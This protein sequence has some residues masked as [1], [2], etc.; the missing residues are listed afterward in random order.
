MKLDYKKWLLITSLS[1][2]GLLSSIDILLNNDRPDYYAGLFVLPL[3]FVFASLLF[4]DI[5]Q[6][7]PENIAATVIILL[8]FVRLVLNPLF[9]SEAGYIETVTINTDINSSYAIFLSCYEILSVFAMIFFFYHSHKKTIN[10]NEK[11]EYNTKIGNPY[12]IA[13]CIMILMA[14]GC[15]LITPGIMEG[16]RSINH[17]NDQYFTNIENGDIINKYST[18]FVT[19]F[20]MVTGNYIIKIL[21]ILVPT[22]LILHC[23]SIKNIFWAKTISFLF[24]FIPFFFIDGAIARSL[25]YVVTLLMLRSYVLN[26]SINKSQGRILVIIFAAAVIVLF[27]WINRFH[28]SNTNSF[29]AFIS[30]KI[31]TYFSGFNIVSG[32]FNLPRNIDYRIRYMLYDFTETFPYGNTIFHISHETIQPFFNKYNVTSGQIPTTIG[33]GYYYF[34]FLL[35]PIY[36]VCFAQ[37]ALKAGYKLKNESNL[38]PKVRLIL[39]S[40]YFSMGIVM[41]NIEITMI[42]FYCIILPLLLLE[43]INIKCTTNKSVTNDNRKD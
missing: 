25:I 13:V 18:D 35:S 22:L 40:F 15:Y 14:V 37:I 26:V 19:K 8:F 16:F 34:G 31:S 5:Y 9:F 33:M 3:C 23:K 29:V 21:V 1:I 4:K 10:N 27:Y 39:T 11:K 36:S 28:H 30:E 43:K 38:L 24:C 2:I 41:Y 20:S 17:I 7:I 42:N 12:K 6:L 32:S